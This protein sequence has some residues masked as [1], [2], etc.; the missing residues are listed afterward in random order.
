[1]LPKKVNVVDFNAISTSSS[2]DVIYTQSSGGQ[3][4]E[5][6]APDNFGGLY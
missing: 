6:Y 3:D 4:V 5:I 1:M 2:V